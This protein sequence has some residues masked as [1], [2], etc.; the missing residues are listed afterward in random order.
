LLLHWWFTNVNRERTALLDQMRL[1]LMA[2]VVAT[3]IRPRLL[4]ESSTSS[5]EVRL[6]LGAM[7]RA[8]SAR[9]WAITERCAWNLSGSE[10]SRGA[11]G[12]CAKRARRELW[13]R[14]RGSRLI[15]RRFRPAP[16]TRGDMLGYR[17][18]FALS[19]RH[20]LRLHALPGVMPAPMMVM[21]YPHR[22]GCIN[23]GGISYAWCH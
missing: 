22:L 14:P 15:V 19:G 9:S 23:S 3:T 11:S 6:A 4:S 1:P 20:A 16:A 21:K 2:W 17:L 10:E 13:R 8:S 5:S 18:A 12:A 7:R